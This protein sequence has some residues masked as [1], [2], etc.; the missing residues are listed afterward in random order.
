VELAIAWLRSQELLPVPVGESFSLTSDFLFFCRNEIYL[1]KPLIAR[2][3][4]HGQAQRDAL[5]ILKATRQYSKGTA[6]EQ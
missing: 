3:W 4:L 2:F 1:I 5:R 6:Y